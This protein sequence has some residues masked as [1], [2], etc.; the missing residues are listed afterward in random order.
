MA[1]YSLILRVTYCGTK[2]VS[3]EKELNISAA[4]VEGSGSS[5]LKI[6]F[7][8]KYD[9]TLDGKKD[10]YKVMAHFQILQQ[11]E[12]EVHSPIQTK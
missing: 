1:E 11:S 2:E 10:S 8:T 3:K 4:K 6:D 12:Q 9:V 7:P 5:T